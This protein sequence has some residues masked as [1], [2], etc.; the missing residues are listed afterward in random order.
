[1]RKGAQFEALLGLTSSNTRIRSRSNELSQGIFSDSKVWKLPDSG[2]KLP[3]FGFGRLENSK[4]PIPNFTVLTFHAY[5][6]ISTELISFSAFAE[7]AFLKVKGKSTL[8]VKY[9]ALVTHGTARS[10]TPYQGRSVPDAFDFGFYAALCTMT[11]NICS[12]PCVG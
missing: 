11:C 1:M 9:Y 4:V 12:S 10:H 5:Q 8:F 6:T 3:G 2:P 7:Y